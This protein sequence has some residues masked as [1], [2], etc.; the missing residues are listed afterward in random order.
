MRQ[1]HH[2]CFSQYNPS[3][4]NDLELFI[5]PI[6]IIESYHISIGIISIL[7]TGYRFLFQLIHVTSIFLGVFQSAWPQQVDDGIVVGFI[8]ED[9]HSKAVTNTMPNLNTCSCSAPNLCFQ[10]KYFLFGWRFSVVWG[11]LSFLPFCT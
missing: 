8:I 6:F 10:C 4:Y 2:Q 11:W 3:S 9:I 5:L 1:I 7:A